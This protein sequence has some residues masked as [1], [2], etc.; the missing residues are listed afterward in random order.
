[1]TGETG[2]WPAALRP[3]SA[4]MFAAWITWPYSSCSLGKSAENAEHMKKIILAI[5]LALTFAASTAAVLTVQTT[6]A[7]AGSCSGA[8]VADTGRRCR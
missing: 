1:M 7:A 8:Q 2:P 3:H 5:M 4:L 6:P